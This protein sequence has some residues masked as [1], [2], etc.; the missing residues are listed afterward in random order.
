MKRFAAILTAFALVL[1][2]A[3]ALAAAPEDAETA[4]AVSAG[5]RAAEASAAAGME[6][7]QG[8]PARSAV[9]MDQA[10]GQ[11]LFAKN[12]HEALPPASVTKVMSLLLVME[13]IDRGSLNVNTEVTCSDHAAAMGGSQIWLEPGE[14]MTVDDLLKA[15]AIG[16][17]NDAAV[18]LAEAVAGT[19][20]AFVA[21]MNRRAAELG[22]KDTA[23][24]NATGLDAPGHVTSAHDIALMAAELLKHPL[25]QHYSTVWMSQ[26][27]GGT[28][29]LVNTNRLVRT[30]QGITGL[31]TGTTA[32][33]GSCLAASAARDGLS[34]V[35]VVM[36]CATSNDRF[37]AGRALLDYGFAT[38][39]RFVPELPAAEL[40]PVAVR[41][42]A[43]RQV[44]AV[45][46]P[47]RGFVVEKRLL[48][49]VRQTVELPEQVEAPVAAGQ[50]LGRVVVRAGD[51]LLGEY[52]VT[53]AAAVGRMT[54]GRAVGLLWRQARAMA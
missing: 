35:A 5:I 10:T 1:G 22:M 46:S 4:P 29:Q 48:P 51:T 39:T 47:G 13:A 41:R 43:V 23:F 14:V 16:S 3:A 37:A 45:C 20:D 53:A 54:F 2:P 31:K 21:Q 44:R 33:A 18:A 8:L 38:Y 17:A 30:Y 34:L 24:K 28:T 15:A 9:L 36:G 32:G 7:G 27:R 6:I 25:I 52:P 50:V 26:L 19:E 49:Q 42:G 40:R 12:E 11:V